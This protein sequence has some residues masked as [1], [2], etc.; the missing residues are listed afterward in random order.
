MISD[1][2]G[3]TRALLEAERALSAGEVPVGAVIYDGD[4]LIA[5]A[6]N[7]REM[8]QDPTAHAEV[9]ALQQAAKHLGRRR[10]NG[11]TMYVT[12][13]PCPM[14]AG[15]L[16]LS[17]IDRVVFGAPDPKGGCCGSVYAIPE[18][19]AFGHLTRCDGPMLADRC[20]EV[21]SRFFKERRKGSGADR[22]AD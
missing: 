6:G 10:L 13:E 8:R 15:A 12:L 19:P 1:A 14:C 4:E 2:E 20:S 16:M 7:E 9:L 11:C 5:A 3:I 17:G 18:D 21:L 22:P